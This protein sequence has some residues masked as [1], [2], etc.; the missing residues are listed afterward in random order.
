MRERRNVVGVMIALVFVFGPAAGYAAGLR[1]A[2]IDNRAIA[3]APSASAGFDALDAV[4]PWA[5]DR[6]A[7]RSTAVRTKSW[8]D[9]H[10]LHEMPTSGQ[11]IR[12]DD[13]YLFLGEDF[14]RGCQ[15]TPSYQGALE[16]LAKLA[17]IIEKSGRRA[18]FTVAPNKSSV[19]TDALPSVVPKGSCALDGIAQQNKVLD[20]FRHP[21]WLGVRR[22]LLGSQTYWRTDSHWS[23]A[24]AAVFARALASHL[25]PR[26]AARITTSPETITKTA[27]LNGLIGLTTAE[28]PPS[29]R[30]STGTTVTPSPGHVAYDPLKVL[31]G[32]EK[33]T[34]RPAAGLIGGKSLISG[35]SFSY[36]ALGNLRSLVADGT[37]LWTGH[38]SEAEIIAEIKGSD[39]VVVEIV[40]RSVSTGH[41]LA[42]AAF[43]DK[44]AAALDVPAN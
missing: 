13:G 34:T 3:P 10:V 18:V 9:F 42:T 44:V 5:S 30:V 28:S 22:Q 11:V 16:G 23:T 12:G 15:L 37:F 26:L 43:Q 35:D 17:E 19:V 4:G 21:S 31:Y 7:G 25:A 2:P 36:F 8:F 33:W 40:Q 27:D 1:Q 24:G 20:S 32:S 29:V 14:T 41:M 6:L 39:T 38:V